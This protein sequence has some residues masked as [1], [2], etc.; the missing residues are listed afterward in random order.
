MTRRLRDGAVPRSS[1]AIAT[2]RSQCHECGCDEVVVNPREG[3]VECKA[4]G[5]V[6]DS[7]ML[8]ERSEWRD[9]SEK[10]KDQNHDPS[11]RF[12]TRFFVLLCTYRT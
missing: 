11:V 6:L 5:L 12:A 9:F 10:D 1:H 4:C 3:R 8:D 2:Q 7:A